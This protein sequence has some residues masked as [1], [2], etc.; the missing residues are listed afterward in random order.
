MK[1]LLVGVFEVVFTEM[2]IIQSPRETPFEAVAGVA[3]KRMGAD[4]LVPEDGIVWVERANPRSR[5][6]SL[7]VTFA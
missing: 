4:W 1:F 5:V 7:F 2:V 3:V 6:R